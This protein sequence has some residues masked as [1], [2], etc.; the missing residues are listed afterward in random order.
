MAQPVRVIL[1]TDI[2]SD[3]DDVGALAM[4][5]TLMDYNRVELLAVVVTSDDPYAPACTDV[6]NHYFGRP[7]IPIGV[8]R[9]I[10][11]K[12]FSRYTRQISEEFPSRIKD[13]NDA[14]DAVGLYRRILANEPDSSV[15][16]ISIGHLTNFAALLLSEGD[17]YS[18][19]SGKDLA[20][21][22]VKLWSCMGG[23]FP[24]GKEANFYRPD[25]AS[26]AIAL[27]H[28]KGKVVFAGWELGNAII[29]GGMFLK[30]MLSEKSPVWRSYE[31]YNN[32]SGRQSWDQASVLYA[33]S[34]DKGYWTLEEQGYCEVFEDGSNRWVSNGQKGNHAYLREKLDPAEIAKIID[35][36]MTG[37]YRDEF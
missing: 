5:H 2:D 1:D 18:A 8:E 26:T 12:H 7:G 33:I 32:F 37:I 17:Q 28:W 24:E 34:P 36:L 13:Y 4:L 21:R 29:T 9:G 30:K 35:A 31:L 27:E 19:L 25:P 10:E 22:K 15:V 3:V 23:M 14:E 11:L 20:A 16:I 6:I